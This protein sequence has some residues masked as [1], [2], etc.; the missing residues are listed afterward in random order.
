MTNYR[1]HCSHKRDKAPGYI[2]W[3]AQNRSQLIRIPAAAS[4]YIRAELRSPDPALNPYIAYALIIYACLDGIE[5]RLE[6]PPAK[7]INL[8]TAPDDILDNI[9]QLP[10]TLKNAKEIAKQSSFINHILCDPII[11]A[12]C[13]Q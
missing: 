4:P 12:Y 10:S 6:L 3:S 11:E 8:F 7:D 13:K 9:K 1:C 5:K 2:S